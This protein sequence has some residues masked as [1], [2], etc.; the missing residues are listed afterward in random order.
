MRTRKL[1]DLPGIHEWQNYVDSSRLSAFGVVSVEDFLVDY[2]FGRE[3]AAIKT[4]EMREFRI[5]CREF[6]DRFVLV[7]NCFCPE[8]MLEGDDQ[9]VFEMF[10]AL[11]E[12]FG[13][14][15]VLSSDDLKAAA[16]EYKS[17]VVEKQKYHEDST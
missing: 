1:P 5:K 2:D 10:G 12:L 9:H 4:S 16:A 11:C 13:T 17:Y 6:I 8:I 3:L 7:D 14:C 15:N